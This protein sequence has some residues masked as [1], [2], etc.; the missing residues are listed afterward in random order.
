MEVLKI[1]DPKNKYFHHIIHRSKSFRVE[2]IYLKDIRIINRNIQK[3]IIVDDT[4]LSFSTNLD[5]GIPIVPF[6]N[7]K[8]DTE[9]L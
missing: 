5:N 2:K 3:V 8:S 6:F 9:L 1:I 4:I 7:D